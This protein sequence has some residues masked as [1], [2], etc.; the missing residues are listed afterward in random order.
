MI[1]CARDGFL[2]WWDFAELDAADAGEDAELDASVAP[3][4]EVFLGENSSA[5]AMARFGN[6]LAIV[7]ESGSI[8]G[9]D[10]AS[11]EV[12]SEL[13]SVA[14]GM[15]VGVASSAKAVCAQR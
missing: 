6:R 14:S 7:D 10:L 3:I 4:R 1:T 15:I 8:K 11:G 5:I 13:R 2:R 9:V 12:S